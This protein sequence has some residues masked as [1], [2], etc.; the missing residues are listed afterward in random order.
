MNMFYRKFVVLSLCLVFVMSACLAGFPGNANAQGGCTELVTHWGKT[1]FT[2]WKARENAR[3]GMGWKI[4]RLMGDTV[5][6]V[7][8]IRIVQ[9]KYRGYEEWQCQ[10]SVIRDYCF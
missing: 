2:K 6:L 5:K 4:R 9:C 10:A 3:A 8:G 7:R 1:A